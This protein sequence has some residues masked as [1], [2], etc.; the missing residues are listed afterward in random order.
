LLTGDAALR[1]AAVAENIDVRGT[2]WLMTELV[3]NQQIS[4]SEAR[5]ALERMRANG[6]RLPWE[7][8]E[9]ALAMQ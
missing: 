2:I 1:Q 5:H 8:A 4:S 7:L 3:R 6:R 9:E